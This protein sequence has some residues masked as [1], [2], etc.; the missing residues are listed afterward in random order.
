VTRYTTL[1]E[2]LSAMTRGEPRRTLLLLTSG[3]RPWLSGSIPR[4]CVAENQRRNGAKSSARTAFPPLRA[5]LLVVVLAIG[6]AVPLARPLYAYTR[7]NPP[8]EAIGP[9]PRKSYKA[10][11]LPPGAL[12]P[13]HQRG[14]LGGKLTTEERAL[15]GLAAVFLLTVAAQWLA[16]WGRVPAALLL[17]VLGCVVGPVS[18]FLEPDLLLGDLLL[19]LISMALALVLFFDSLTVRQLRAADQ[20]SV[21]SLASIGL[22][23][24]WVLGATAACFLL[25]LGLSLALLF[26]L[27][28]AL[29]GPPGTL[30]SMRRGSVKELD[31]IISGERTITD[32]VGTALV[33]LIFEGILAGGFS[34]FGSGWIKFRDTLGWGLFFGGFSGFG[35]SAWIAIRNTLGFGL[36]FGGCGGGLLLVLL[37]RRWIPRSVQHAVPL[38]LALTVFAVSSLIQAESGFL[39]VMIMGTLASSQETVTLEYA[40]R[41]RGRWHDL[42]LAAVFLALVARI[43]IE[44]LVPIGVAGAVFVA[45]VVLSSRPLA[46][47]L[48]TLSAAFG[49][50][51][52]LLLSLMAPRGVL[53]AGLATICGLRLAETRHPEAAVWVPLTLLVVGGTVATCALVPLVMGRPQASVTTDT[54]TASKLT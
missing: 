14:L 52:R 15:E 38:M 28:L 22:A 41:L 37:Q 5:W 21:R 53:A 13:R 26:G 45:V 49:W 9:R 7:E 18:G 1:E 46:V 17:L 31:A 47:G 11:H 29:T 32:L 44:D 51:E 33:I 35:G 20:R 10:L 39:A 4:C 6:A 2:F 19:P 3:F 36:F 30:A 48:S 24:A 12:P 50:R 40:R 8:W 16:V 34:G 27:I 42:L 54:E 25:Q 43:R 23:I